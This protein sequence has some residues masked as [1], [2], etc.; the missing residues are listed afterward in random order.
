[1]VLLNV[2]TEVRGGSMSSSFTPSSM[3]KVGVLSVKV[4][5][6][7]IADRKPVVVMRQDLWG[8]GAIYHKD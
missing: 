7:N 5:T 2:V 8:A 4:T 1:M 3:M 6:G